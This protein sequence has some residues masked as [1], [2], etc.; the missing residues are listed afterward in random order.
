M[1]PFTKCIY[2]IAYTVVYAIRYVYHM[3]V[4]S[5]LDPRM[6]YIEVNEHAIHMG[7]AEM[8]LRIAV[9]ERM[10]YQAWCQRAQIEDLGP[11]D[12]HPS[13]ASYLHQAFRENGESF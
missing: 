10:T 1:V 6:N 4:L 13:V 3:I 12:V 8:H 11:Q 5:F 9:W 2:L 7:D